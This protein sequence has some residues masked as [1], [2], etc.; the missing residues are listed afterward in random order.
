MPVILSET[1]RVIL[2]E[3]ADAESIKPRSPTPSFSRKRGKGRFSSSRFRVRQN[4]GIR[5]AQLISLRRFVIYA[6]F[7]AKRVK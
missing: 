7:A 2:R 6:F 4:A 5:F 3:V 1:K